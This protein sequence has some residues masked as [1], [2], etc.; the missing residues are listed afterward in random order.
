MP[1]YS[2]ARDTITWRLTPS[3]QYITGSAYWLQFIGA[4]G[5]I[6]FIMDM[7]TPPKYK[8]APF[9]V[10]HTKTTIDMMAHCMLS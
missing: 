8:S 1:T 6:I 4:T 5:T 9:V 2:G 10:Q 3:R 7:L